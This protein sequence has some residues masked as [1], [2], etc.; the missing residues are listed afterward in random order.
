MLSAQLNQT[1][2]LV[3]QKYATH[4]DEHLLQLLA[5]IVDEKLFEAIAPE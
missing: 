2:T 5:S 4:L 1:N 3:Y